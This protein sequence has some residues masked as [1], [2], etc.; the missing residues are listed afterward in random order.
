MTFKNFIDANN[1]DVPNNLK[2]SVCIIG[3]GAAGITLANNLTE[4]DDV[5][6]IESGDF[7]IDG[8]TQAL[9]SGSNIGLPYFDLLGCR[10]RYFGGTTNH[11]GGY[12]RPNDPIDYEGREEMALPKWP[13]EEKDLYPFISQAAKELG[14]S[15]EFYKP[16]LLLTAKGA[17]TDEL[18]ENVSSDFY[19]KI[20]QITKKLRFSQI[21]RD[22]LSK[23]NNLRIY[24]NLNAIHIQ[25]SSDASRV[26]SIRCKTLGGKII[27]VEAKEFILA[28]HA[29]ENA[30]LLLNSN[31][32]RPEGVGNQ[33]DHVGRYFMDH[34]HISAS[35]LIPSDKFPSIYNSVSSRKFNLNANLSFTDDYL[36][37]KNILQ[38][39]C[40]FNPVYV[41]EKVVD[42]LR[43]INNNIMEP[44]S[45]ELFNDIKSVMNNFTGS[46]DFLSARYGVSQS[47]PKYYSLDH[48]IEQAPNPDSR[49]VISKTKDALD[50]P[51]ADLQWKLN[52]HD[53]HTFRLGHEKVIKELSALGMGRFITEEITSELVDE[54]IAGHNH[55]IGTTKMSKYPSDGVVDKDCKVHNLSNLHVAGSSIFPT[56]GY[57]GPTMMIVAFAMRLAKHISVKLQS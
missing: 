19:T 2:T 16:E 33:Y 26:S 29:I 41:D 14:L 39:Y 28:S 17:P 3:A 57:S 51:Q 38:Y 43:G 6:L 34:V 11:W 7:E 40:R 50:V 56:A 37:K 52:E 21:Y 20:F 36:R 44:F 10:L 13:I 4:I 9:Y 30:R 27:T 8:R 18:L 49:V 45:L 35:K 25:L 15:T 1:E 48:R 23:Q 54:R 42:S 32:I 12:C 47:L 46:V 55:H 24:L 22:K 5:L 53:Y 31:D